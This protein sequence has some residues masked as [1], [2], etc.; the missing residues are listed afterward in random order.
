[1]TVSSI[2]AVTGGADRGASA[3]ITAGHATV[4]AVAGDAGGAAPASPPG[5]PARRAGLAL[6]R[7]AGHRAQGGSRPARLLWAVAATAVAA[8][9]LVSAMALGALQWHPA[10]FDQLDEQAHFDYAVQLSE[11][12]IP[13][14]GDLYR[15]ATVRILDCVGI[16]RPVPQP[17]TSGSDPRRFPPAGYSYEAQQPPL[18]YLA[19]LPFLQGH[20]PP[21]RILDDARRGGW[22]WLGAAAALLLAVAWLAD[23]NLL[24]TVVLL[25]LCELNP[26]AIRAAATVTN[27]AAALAAGALCIAVVQ[28]GRRRESTMVVAA[29]AAGAI[30]GL[31]KSLFCVV[32]LALVIGGLLAERPGAPGFTWRGLWRRRGCALMLLAGSGVATVAFS[33]VQELRAVTAP[34]VVLTALLGGRVTAHPRWATLE[35]S[36]WNAFSVFQSADR[37]LYSLWN[38]LI[39]GALAGLALNGSTS[40]RRTLPALAGGTMVALAALGVAF[41][42][43][44]YFQGH[45][46]FV[47]Q[48]RYAVA[49]VPLVAYLLARS[50]RPSGLVLV[51]VVLPALAVTSTVM[52]HPF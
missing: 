47:I 8:G 28:V 10:T 50:L 22:L 44:D 4:L 39:F 5:G 21:V 40:P 20:G 46:N 34:K 27:D 43:L 16:G 49:I 17:C 41:S 36:V 12:H 18:G 11:G 51:G 15:P 35:G 33:V 38:L 32:P 19:Y 42:M 26:S 29:L 3:V 23:M 13:K 1:M 48:A 30:V 37:P 45:F 24:Q 52:G 2:G 14:W 31:T 25:S 9:L 7:V 6:R